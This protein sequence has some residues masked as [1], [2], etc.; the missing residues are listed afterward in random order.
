[1]LLILLMVVIILLLLLICNKTYRWY[2]LSYIFPLLNYNSNIGT[3]LGIRYED[4]TKWTTNR[5]QSK[6]YM[7]GMFIKMFTTFTGMDL[8]LD[9]TTRKEFMRLQAKKSDNIN[10]SK[11]FN[12]LYGKTIKVTEFEDFLAEKILI[13]SNEVFEIIDKESEQKII[14][15]MQILRK[16]INSLTG[17]RLLGIYYFVVYYKDVKELSNILKSAPKYK[18]LLLFVPQ[19]TLINNFTQMI[20]SNDGNISDIEPYHFLEPIS[21]FMVVN[22][23]G[24]L[25]FVKRNFDKTNFPTNRAFGPKGLQCPGS[26]YTFK[27]INSILNSLKEFNISIN[28][29]P[30]YSNG[31]FKYIMNKNSIDFTFNH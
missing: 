28:G 15:H 1:M 13:E 16:I 26:I 4:D 20:I 9:N 22:N 11:Y 21:K 30:L 5:N 3:I 8:I 12:E 19:L 14:K 7:T 27:F 25:V 31:R 29:K 18:R 24:Q 10:I 2:L 6:I 17:N 23:N